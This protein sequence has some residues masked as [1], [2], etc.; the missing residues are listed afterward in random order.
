M[1]KKKR[2]REREN[3]SGLSR[4]VQDGR[5]CGKATG[6][7]SRHSSRHGGSRE[8]AQ[9]LVRGKQTILRICHFCYLV[10]NKRLQNYYPYFLTIPSYIFSS[11]LKQFTFH[12]LHFTFNADTISDQLL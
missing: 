7:S 11:A 8:L 6:G 4:E 5:G 3:R 10:F 9:Y 2:E 1:N 12:T